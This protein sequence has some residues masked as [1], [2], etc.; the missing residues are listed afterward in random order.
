LV[1]IFRISSESGALEM[2]EADVMLLFSFCVPQHFHADVNEALMKRFGARF[3]LLWLRIGRTDRPHGSCNDNW[4][5]RRCGAS[6]SNSR[7][8]ENVSARPAAVP[9]S[10][11]RQNSRDFWKVA[12]CEKNLVLFATLFRTS[13]LRVIFCR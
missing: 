3:F 6:K 8:R 5:R 7:H 12:A 4:N 11:L 13:L 9:F 10:N 1:S 2:I